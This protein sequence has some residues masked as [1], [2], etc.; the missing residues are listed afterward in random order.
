[1]REGGE[2]ELRR[3]PYYTPNRTVSEQAQFSRLLFNKP[4]SHSGD[5]VQALANL[6]VQDAIDAQSSKGTS[7]PQRVLQAILAGLQESTETKVSFELAAYPVPSLRVR[8]GGESL[9]L[10]QLPDGLRA[11]LGWMVDAALMCDVACGRELDPFT[12]P[13]IFLFDEVEAHLH[14]KWQRKLLPAFQRM[15]PAA[16]IFVATHSPFV[17]SSLN[18]GW[19]HVLKQGKAGKIVAQEPKAASP[20]DSYPS[21]LAEIMDV[22]EWYDVETEKLLAEFRKLRNA[23]LAGNAKAL[24]KTRAM[25]QEIGQRSHDLAGI[26]GAELAR[27]PKAS[28]GL[29]GPK[30]KSLKH[31][32][33]APAG[34]GLAK[35]A[36]SKK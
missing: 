9:A 26:M 13:A 33:P 35:P 2:E 15:F 19:I 10:N 32:L 4:A 28:T 11:L 23:A 34:H 30:A 36:I 16:Q 6:L 27:L 12:T 14:P 29:P 1:M 3:E 20:G 17:I 22:E 7:R 18:C 21:V 5:F 24:V 8:W 31:G 25:G